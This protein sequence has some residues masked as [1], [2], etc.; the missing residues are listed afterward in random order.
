MLKVSC[1]HPSLTPF[2]K[3]PFPLE[4]QGAHTCYQPRP[5]GEIRQPQAVSFKEVQLGNT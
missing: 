5:N 4:P 2:N 1:I 3:Q